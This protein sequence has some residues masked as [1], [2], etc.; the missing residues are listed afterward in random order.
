MARVGII[1]DSNYFLHYHGPEGVPWKDLVSEAE[2]CLLVVP[3]VAGEIDKKKW[4]GKTDKER[5]RARDITLNFKK[6]FH[7]EKLPAL[8][9][10]ITIE[11][12]RQRDLSHVGLDAN[13]PDD[14]ILLYSL[15][16]REDYDQIFLLTHDFGLQDRAKDYKLKCLEL[17]DR[18]RL[19]SEPDPVE[20]ELADARRELQKFK[21]RT[22]KLALS[23]PAGERHLEFPVKTV[24]PLS[25]LELKSAL[26]ELKLKHP[27]RAARSIQNSQ[28]SLE[29]LAQ[30][31][32]PTAEVWARYNADM[33]DFYK[34]HEQYLLAKNEYD[35]LT[36]RTL[37]IFLNLGNAG[38]AKASNIR[39][40]LH[41][42]ISKTATLVK[43][44]DFIEA[45]KLPALPREPEGITSSIFTDVNSF[46]PSLRPIVPHRLVRDVV[47]DPDIRPTNSF[48][49]SFKVEALQHCGHQEIKRLYLTFP[50]VEAAESF[51]IAWSV[52]CDEQPEPTKGSLNVIVC[53]DGE[54]EV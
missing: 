45:P 46:M 3:P 34:K 44:K 19:Q 18:Y 4:D 32:G 36:A 28:S 31:F 20:K 14:L 15:S 9:S 50:S 42:P 10:G 37:K 1:L 29:L 22:P 11:R 12:V 8:Q 16:L 5:N 6:W 7:A 48:D 38:T 23:F 17:E 13:N 25:K 54:P 47:S 39:I 41:F 2:I 24:A 27:L 21:D 53:K 43:E 51:Q 52:I 26:N 35:A 40:D 33:E 30:M 49:V